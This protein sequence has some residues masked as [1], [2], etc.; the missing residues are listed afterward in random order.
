MRQCQCE[1]CG[2]Q[3]PMNDTLRVGDRILCDAC[4]EKVLP[5]AEADAPAVDLERQIDP[6]V[7]A[8]C[9]KDNG[10]E[11]LSRLAEMPVC[12]P[13]ETFFR[14][15]PFPAWIKLSLAAVIVLVGVSLVW[16][17]RFFR[18]YGALRYSWACFAEGQVEVAAAQMASAAA[19]VPECEDIRVV[20]DY[21]EGVSLLSQDRYAEAVAKLSQCQ[22]QMPPD[23]DVEILLAQAQGGVA[24]DNKDYDGFLAAA[25]TYDRKSPDSYMGK[26]MMAS[27][28]ACKHAQSGDTGC[29]ERSLECLKQAE[30]L[31]LGDPG[32]AEYESRILHRLQSR[33]IITRQEYYERFPEGWSPEKED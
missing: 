9:Q 29:R 1:Q 6:T 11:E 3:F 25:Q 24:F 26:A 31:A 15:R 33:Q 5:A 28:W 16:N 21:M 8:T 20:S 4:C 32:F 23:S 14:N 19:Y 17:L 18:A 12:E 22:S 10:T 30:N 7:C 27:A 13:C 2:G